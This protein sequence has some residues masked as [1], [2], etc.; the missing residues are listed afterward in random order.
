MKAARLAGPKHFEFLEVDLPDA[1]DGE[2][3]V[4]LKRVSAEGNDIRHGYAPIEPEE[5]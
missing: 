1:N 3:L 2:S 4:K 5:H